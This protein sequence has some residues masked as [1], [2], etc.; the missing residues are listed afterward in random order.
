MNDHLKRS[1]ITK[2]LTDRR[3]GLTF[4]EAE[5]RLDSVRP[6][7]ELGEDQARTPAGQAAALTAVATAYKCFGSVV[8]VTPA[9]EARLIHPLF[10][11]ATV[12]EAARRLGATVFSARPEGEFHVVQVGGSQGLKG[13]RLRCWWDRWLTGARSHEGEPLGDSRLP[14]AGTF[15]GALCVRQIF[16][17][18]VAGGLTERDLTV[19]L[20]EPWT[21][22]D[23]EQTGPER[24]ELPNRLWLLGLGHLGQGFGWNLGFMPYQGP[25]RVVVQD[26][27][28]I[29]E[30]N[31]A[32]SLLVTAEDIGERKTRAARRWLEARGWQVD[33]IERRNF[34][35]VRLQDE[36]PPYLVGGLD[37]LPPRKAMAQVGFEYMVDVGIGRGPVDF[38][39]IQIRVIPKGA[40]AGT[41]WN[42]EAHEDR[43]NRL[44]ESEPYK[45]L[46]QTQGQCGTFEIADASVSVPFVGAAAGA[47]ALAQ[48]I[49]LASLEA[50]A[51]LLQLELHAP[52]MVLHPGFV[53]PPEM[54]LGAETCDLGRPWSAA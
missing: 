26:D 23:L 53:T 41:L 27:Q 17:K 7:V 54:N 51:R 13:W 25:R 49:R 50:A 6:A 37:K 48:L 16:A 39:G 9:A 18:V 2:A 38:E 20:W 30:E 36:D 5:A 1:R 10:I 33:M 4:P 21:S 11:G 46:Q 35:D 8:L 28:S 22:V 29:A 42:V 14:L 45:A 47:L 40:D 44:I 32:T 34:G 15:S 24:F 12:G 3:Q 19:S 43:T 52:E 31:E